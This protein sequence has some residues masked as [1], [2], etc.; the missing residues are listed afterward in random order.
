MYS[1]DDFNVTL[2]FLLQQ[3]AWLYDRQLSQVRAQMRKVGNTQ[4]Q[5]PGTGS[6]SGSGALGGQAMRRAGSGG[7]SLLRIRTVCAD[8]LGS[9]APSRLSA[10]QKEIQPARDAAQKDMQPAR[11]AARTESSSKAK[12]IAPVRTNS[13]TTVTQAETERAPATFSGRPRRARP[14]L[15]ILQRPPAE[16]TESPSFSPESNSES[17][18][19]LD[20]DDDDDD[21]DDVPR[22]FGK[23]SMH[24]PS[25]R[26]DA[27]DESPAFLPLPRE[28]Q[29]MHS[30][31]RQQEPRRQ[32][33]GYTPS[34]RRDL[35]SL[36]SS[37]SSGVAVQP[38]SP[39]VASLSRESSRRHGSA[40][41]SNEDTVSMGS[42]F[43]D[44]DGTPP[45]LIPSRDLWL[46]CE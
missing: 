3:A 1:A 2:S 21:D 14:S 25:L 45:S 34:H 42:S 27:D 22:R 11:D 15:A 8:W 23:Y 17:D 32:M 20:N 38:V 5:S 39:R 29:H 13:A 12:G 41:Q 43:S 9:R 10:V 4:S 44:L 26:D 19:D 40:H 28:E 37:A 36:D 16:E 35:A 31:L 6:V 18:S 46:T 7:S 33:T 30:T 24:K